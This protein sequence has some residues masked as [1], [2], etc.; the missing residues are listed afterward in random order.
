MSAVAVAAVFLSN[1]P[2]GLSSSAGMKKAGKRMATVFGL[3]GGI[4]LASGVA[5][6][7]G[8]LAFDNAPVEAVSFV[9]S[10]AAG[11]ILAMIVD[12]MVPEAFAETH[13]YS[14]LIAV[15]GFISAFALSRMGA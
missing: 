9:Q 7:V 2:E 13:E 4:A 6:L 8:F 10:L 14:G 12:T 3:W 11:A 15:A 5:A 1:I